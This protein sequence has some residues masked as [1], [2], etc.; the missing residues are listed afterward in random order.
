MKIKEV[1]EFADNEF[2]YFNK[3]GKKLVYYNMEK[4]TFL[5]IYRKKGKLEK[6]N[7]LEMSEEGK[8]NKKIKIKFKL[9]GKIEVAVQRNQKENLSLNNQIYNDIYLNHISIYDGDGTLLEQ[10]LSLSSNKGC[11][12]KSLK[13]ILTT[14]NQYF[15]NNKTKLKVSGENIELY[16]KDS[17]RM[18]ESLAI[19]LEK[20]NIC[21][22][23]AKT[24]VKEDIEELDEEDKIYKN[25]CI[26]PKNLHIYDRIYEFNRQAQN[27]ISYISTVDGI[28][29]LNIKLNHSTNSVQTLSF[30]INKTKKIAT[31]YRGIILRKEIE[32]S[33]MIKI[34]TVDGN[35]MRGSFVL[36]SNDNIKINGK[37]ESISRITGR[38]DY[39][40]EQRKLISNLDI[41][42]KNDRLKLNS[43][44]TLY[45][46]EEEDQTYHIS[47]EEYS[48]FANLLTL[49][50]YIIKNIENNI[51]QK[52]KN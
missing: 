39:D 44:S 11:P 50:P 20:E 29:E 19:Y 36:N 9:N 28:W 4:K 13:K 49:S 26:I 18:I 52:K 33:V 15:D 7:L 10:R 51:W 23:K 40:Q 24:I 12:N 32:K 22:E 35:L 30:N 34:N 8:V 2:I 21:I 14:E 25:H 48:L 6:I 1:I 42:L 45:D 38:A 27:V 31:E 16:E 5:E 3:K 47:S 41:R 46:F 43:L 17:N 37:T